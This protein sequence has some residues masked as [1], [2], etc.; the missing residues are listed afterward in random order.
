MAHPRKLKPRKETRKIMQP[1]SRDAF[2]KIL[3][4]I[5]PRAPRPASK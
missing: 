1:I 4:R 2:H 3:N 5:T